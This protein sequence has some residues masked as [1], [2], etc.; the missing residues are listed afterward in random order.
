MRHDRLGRWTGLGRAALIAL[1]LWFIAPLAARAE[2]LLVNG[3]FVASDGAVNDHLGQAVAVSGDMLVATAPY[4]SINAVPSGAAYLFLRDP[5]TGAW[6]ERKKLVPLDGA[7]FDQFGSSV[8]VAGDTIA[9]GAPWADIAGVKEQGAV[10]VF[11]RNAGGSDNW[12]QVAKL[13]DASAGPS[14]NLG[15]AVALSGDLLAVGVP[16]ADH[17]QGRVLLFE[18]DRGGADAWGKAATIKFTDVGSTGGG[19]GSKLP[20]F[21]GAIA[22]DGDRLLVGATGADVSY[23]NEE[24]GAAYLFARDPVDRDRW[25]YVTRLVAHDAAIC[26]GGRFLSELT[27]ESADT[28]AEVERCA[29]EDSATD[30]DA[31]GAAVTLEGDTAIIGA[32][33]AEGA[34]GASE[35]GAVYVFQKDATA[36]GEQWHETAKLAPGAGEG[37][38]FAAFG[39]AVALSSDTLLVGAGSETIGPKDYQ[40]AAYVFSRDSAGTG[41]W[42]EAKHLIAA[43]GFSGDQFGAGVAFDGVAWVI[44]APGHDH[45]RG[46]VYRQEPVS[47]PPPPVACQ[48]AIAP[49]WELGDASVIQGPSG[50]M[51]GAVNGTLTAPSACLAQRGAGPVRAVVRP[52][53]T[54]RRLLQC[55]RGMHHVRPPGCAVRASTAGA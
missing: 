35:V 2:M 45:Y 33:Y 19:D 1:G 42:S 34:G 28:R 40:G 5:A 47:A 6:I 39:S 22:L 11:E 54:A 14:A 15:A 32:R 43:D 41:A 3:S 12:G 7:S 48:P 44:G 29:R 10:Y 46:A 55:R 18:R 38:D 31:F 20:E 36:P 24:D 49:T 4:A 26:F 53:R 51:L 50:S 27:Q 13:T 52:C 21:G 9:I 25:T 37:G 8:A 23:T 16:K 17:D 30:R